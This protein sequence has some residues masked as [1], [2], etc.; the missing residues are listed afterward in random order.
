MNPNVEMSV[1][2]GTVVTVAIV[3]AAEVVVIVEGGVDGASVVTVVTA[4]RAAR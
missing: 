1:A 4:N 3:E 2:V